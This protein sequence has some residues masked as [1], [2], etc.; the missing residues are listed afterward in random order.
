MPSIEIIG[1]Y[2]LIAANIA[3]NYVLI[4][5]ATNTLILELEELNSALGEAVS[6]VVSMKPPELPQDFNPIQ[7][8]IAQWITSSASAKANTYTLAESPRDVNGQFVGKD[9]DN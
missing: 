1:I 5:G 6:T 7:A 3:W 8:A 2:A 9:V 4:S